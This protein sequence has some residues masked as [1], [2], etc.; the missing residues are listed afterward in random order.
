MFGV[1][2]L[3]LMECHGMLRRYVSI[4]NL[5]RALISL[6]ILKQLLNDT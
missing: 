5:S 1:D 6:L 3:M 4:F 2:A